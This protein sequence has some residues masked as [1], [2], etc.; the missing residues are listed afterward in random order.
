MSLNMFGHIDAVFVSTPATRTVETGG[1]YVN[2]KWVDGT[3]EIKPHTVNLQP[4]NDKEIQALNIGAER[5]GDLR[6]IY[7]N[8]GD[9]YN[10][11]PSDI[12]SFTG[13]GGT[14]K[15]VSLDNRPWR[16]YCKIIVSKQDE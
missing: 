5:I 13:L 2:G 8:D 12:W 14:F 4:V 11:K 1:S 7:V 9:L 6:K 15:A 16:N 10:I 3:T